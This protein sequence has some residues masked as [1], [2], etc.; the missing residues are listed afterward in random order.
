MFHIYT[1]IPQFHSFYG[2][3]ALRGEAS[4]HK[5]GTL[6]KRKKMLP[7]V[8]YQLIIGYSLFE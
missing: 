5:R 2:F 3:T 7:A 8:S 6:I 1:H 4:L